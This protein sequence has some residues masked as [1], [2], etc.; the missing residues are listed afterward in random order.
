MIRAD[1]RDP[2]PGFCVARDRCDSASYATPA[3]EVATLPGAAAALLGSLNNHEPDGLTPTAGALSG[4]IA[5]AQALARANPTHKVAV[6]LATDGLPSECDPTDIR[7]ISAIASAAQAANPSVPTFVIGVFGPDEMADAQ[8]NLDAIAAAGGTGKAFVISTNAAN[9]TTAFVNALNAVRTTGLSCQYEVP[10]TM[11]DGGA[12]DY[13]RV[14]VQFTSGSGQE[15]TIGN[16][17]NRAAC[18]A[19]KGG[20]YF[21]VDPTTGAIP[22]TISICDTSCAQMRADPAGKVDILLGCLTIIVG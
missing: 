1:H 12:V 22:K 15:V 17:R 21:D 14:N 11:Q 18:S 9:V 4:A 10:A 20:W 19:T 8:V 7:G 5:R 2:I 13:S 3:V 6:L 16:V